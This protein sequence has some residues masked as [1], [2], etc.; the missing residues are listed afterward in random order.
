[1]LSETTYSQMNCYL[2]S[3]IPWGWYIL[4]FVNDVLHYAHMYCIILMSRFVHQQHI[5]SWVDSFTD[6]TWWVEPVECR[7]EKWFPFVVLVFKMV[8]WFTRSTATILNVA[9]KR[10]ENRMIQPGVPIKECV[11]YSEAWR[12]HNFF[13]MAS[14]WHIEDP[15]EW[16]LQLLYE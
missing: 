7:V 11:I 15:S 9:S 10:K 8:K 5:H 1:M 3:S 13:V 4:L 14:A 16:V 12:I 2:K 6:D